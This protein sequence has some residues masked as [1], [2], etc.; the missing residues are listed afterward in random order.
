MEFLN[1]KLKIIHRNLRG[2]NIFFIEEGDE[3]KA[4]VGD[5]GCSLHSLSQNDDFRTFDIGSRKWMVTL[6]KKLI[7]VN[8][9]K[10]W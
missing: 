1:Q 4:V 5:F 8:L 9:L 2:K 3:V 10:K 6:K 7:Y